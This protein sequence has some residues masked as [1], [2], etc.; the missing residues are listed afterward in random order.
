MVPFPSPRTAA[1][2]ELPRPAK[3]L[4]WAAEAAAAAAFGG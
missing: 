4:T 1:W 2:A 3:A